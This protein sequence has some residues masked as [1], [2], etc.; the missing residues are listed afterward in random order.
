MR[1]LLD[2]NVFLWFISGNEKLS[3]ATKKIIADTNNEL[4]LS[5]ASLW[6]IAIKTSIG[7]LELLQPFDQLVSNHITDNEINIMQIEPK[8][9]SLLI[10]LPF[11]HRDPFDRLII[12]QGISENLPI[13]SSDASFKQYQIEVIGNSL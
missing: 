3:S 12:A 4:F 11:H 6:E 2:T 9:L 8:H 13:L 5:I 7:K 10:K 1:A